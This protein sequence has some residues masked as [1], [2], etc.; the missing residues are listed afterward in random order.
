M[1]PVVKAIEQFQ[2]LF[3][4]SRS[5]EVISKLIEPLG[6]VLRWDPDPVKIFIPLKSFIQDSCERRVYQHFFINKDGR[7]LEELTAESMLEAVKLVRSDLAEQ[8]TTYTKAFP[9]G[10]SLP[11]VTAP[12]Y[13]RL[14]CHYISSYMKES[15]PWTLFKQHEEL[16]NEFILLRGDVEK[17]GL[18]AQDF[19]IEDLFTNHL[20]HW[21][22]SLASRMTHLV[23]SAVCRE[24]WEPLSTQ[25]LISISVIVEK[26]CLQGLLIDVSKD[27][28][29][30]PHVSNSL[31]WPRA[32][33]IQMNN[34]SAVLEEQRKLKSVLMTKWQSSS[35]NPEF[36]NGFSKLENLVQQTLTELITA[37]LESTQGKFKYFLLK[38]DVAE[39]DE[40]TYP[41]EPQL[42][43]VKALDHEVKVLRLSLYPELME[44]FLRNLP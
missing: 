21:I 36:L 8:V 12:V 28:G 17:L 18:K 14:V 26:H 6:L 24:S 30:G 39:C 1:K 38:E 41:I 32:V 31:G 23:D 7:K 19:G 5:K 16:L 33:S 37:A 44:Q 34:V 9:N 3:P 40:E 42:P 11:Q 15:S 35:L 43:L 13:Y 25:P 27:H 10:F 4:G 20:E 22:G 2:S 29:N